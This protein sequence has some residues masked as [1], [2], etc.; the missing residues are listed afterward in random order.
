M[1][2]WIEMLPVDTATGRLKDLFDTKGI[3]T[4]W[5]AEPF[6]DR[7][8]ETDARVVTLLRAAGAVLLGKVA[9][10]QGLVSFPGC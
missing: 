8:P 10:Q 2:A 3:V 9:K 5:G 4:G 1:T 6:R 7:V